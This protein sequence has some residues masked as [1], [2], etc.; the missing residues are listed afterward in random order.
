M[1]SFLNITLK[2]CHYNITPY[3]NMFFNSKKKGLCILLC[4]IL[5]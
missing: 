4:L 3:F 5:N 2:D 1:F